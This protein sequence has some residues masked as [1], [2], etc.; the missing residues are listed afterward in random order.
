MV[1]GAN[2]NEHEKNDSFSRAGGGNDSDLEIISDFRVKPPGTNTRS[3]FF[4]NHIPIIP[5]TGKRVGSVLG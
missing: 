2:V 1:G 4:Q 5:S 3:G